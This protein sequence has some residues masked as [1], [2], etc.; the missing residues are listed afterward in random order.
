MHFFRALLKMSYI[1]P[2]INVRGT[3]S[4]YLT[5]AILKRYTVFD[6]N[7]VYGGRGIQWN[8]N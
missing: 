8:V 1:K 6:L 7:E 3:D 4:L 2:S 5:V